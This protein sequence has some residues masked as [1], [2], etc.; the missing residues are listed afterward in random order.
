MIVAKTFLECR[1]VIAKKCFYRWIVVIKPICVYTSRVA[2]RF[3]GGS[4]DG[5]A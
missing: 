5:R 4:V 1:A 3:C 2:E